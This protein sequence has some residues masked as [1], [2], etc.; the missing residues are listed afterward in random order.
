[1][2]VHILSIISNHLFC[3]TLW[4][5]HLSRGCDV[6]VHGEEWVCDCA[7]YLLHMICILNY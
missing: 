3:V 4:C 1:M 6:G 7:S 2:C 5:V